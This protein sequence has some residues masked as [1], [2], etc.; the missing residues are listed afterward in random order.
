MGFGYSFEEDDFIIVAPKPTEG[1]CDDLGGRDWENEDGLCISPLIDEGTELSWSHINLNDGNL[2]EELCTSEDDDCLYLYFR[3]GGII[4]FNE[5]NGMCFIL[6]KDIIAP[7]SVIDLSSPNEEQDE[8][9]KEFWEKGTGIYDEAPDELCDEYY[10]PMSEPYVSQYEEEDDYDWTNDYEWSHADAAG[11]MSDDTGDALVEITMTQGTDLNWAMLKVTIKVD[12]GTPVACGESDDA[13][14]DCTW[15]PFG[16]PGNYQAWEAGEG[17][18][19]SE[20][21]VDLCSG[22]DG[23]CKIRVTITKKGTGSDADVVIGIMNAYANGY[24]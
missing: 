14:A 7:P 11:S 13:E 1:N 18:T 21:D 17:I 3:A 15:A 2:G 16:G 22:S 19:I 4:L 6:V 10:P 23:G 20:G 9:L 5:E 8:W 24:N 12:G